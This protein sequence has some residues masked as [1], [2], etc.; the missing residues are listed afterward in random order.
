M[1]HNMS[2]RTLCISGANSFGIYGDKL[3]TEGCHGA[4]HCLKDFFLFLALT[5]S[6]PGAKAS[7]AID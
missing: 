7:W 4:L 2:G 3:I 6:P 5:K 1:V